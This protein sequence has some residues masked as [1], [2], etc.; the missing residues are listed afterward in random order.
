MASKRQLNP[1]R[2]D[3]SPREKRPW[4]ARG[5]RIRS[6]LMYSDETL[7]KA[8]TRIEELETRIK[9]LESQIEAER[10]ASTD[11]N[12]ELRTEAR[13]LRTEAENARSAVDRV[14]KLE[15]LDHQWQSATGHETPAS[16][17]VERN[18]V[19]EAAIAEDPVYGEEQTA[20]GFR[21]PAV[22]VGERELPSA[23]RTF[24][25]GDWTHIATATAG[26]DVQGP[27]IDVAV[28]NEAGT[29]VDHVVM[30]NCEGETLEAAL[31]LYVERARQICQTRK[32]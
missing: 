7:D 25:L 6:D 19:L 16:Y 14:Q 1:H 32:G 9:E 17:V 11:R 23:V 27:R 29:P 20:A 21:T 4:E 3:P 22:Y 10:E 26:H 30:R 28:R 8:G 12:M 2:H 31:D 18:R 15:E 13:G 5:W 24:E